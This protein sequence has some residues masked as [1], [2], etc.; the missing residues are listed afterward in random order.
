[1]VEEPTESSSISEV[2]SSLSTDD[3][4]LTAGGFLSAAVFRWCAG[5][6]NATGELIEWTQSMIVEEEQLLPAFPGMSGCLTMG[7]L[8]GV[9]EGELKPLL[10][11]LLAAFVLY[12]LP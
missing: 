2:L 4:G 7:T 11:G 8:L 12:G 3:C 5:G 6:G 10:Y 9:E 1:M